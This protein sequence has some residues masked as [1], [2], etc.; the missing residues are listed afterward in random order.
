MTS[1]LAEARFE[2]GLRKLQPPWS[3][4]RNVQ[5]RSLRE[6]DFILAHPDHGLF[7]VE[8]KG[9]TDYEVDGDRLY[10]HY[11]GRRK[12]VFAQV[13]DQQR[14]LIGLCRNYHLGCSVGWAVALP[15]ANPRGAFPHA[16]K[17][18][19]AA[20]L[21][22]LGGRLERLAESWNEEL[23]RSRGLGLVGVGDRE[24]TRLRLAFEHDKTPRL[25]DIR[26]DLTG[27]ARLTAEQLAAARKVAGMQ[28]PT[29]TF[30]GGAGSGKTVLALKL[31]EEAACAG[32]RVLYLCYNRA[33]KEWLWRKRDTV[34]DVEGL[35]EHLELAHFHRLAH[36]LARRAGLGEEWD[37]AFEADAPSGRQNFWQRTSAELLERAL[38]E[39]ET[40]YDLVIV[41]EAQ[42]FRAPWWPAVEAL[43]KPDGR[44]IIFTDEQQDVFGA[45]GVPEQLNRT[46]F[47]LEQNVRNTR[48][49]CRFI[50]E[51][52]AAE[53]LKIE[54]RHCADA[55]PG[56]EPERLTADE[57]E[58]TVAELLDGG[59]S[60]RQLALLGPFNLEK[61][62][63]VG[64][65]LA[66]RSVVELRR[67]PPGDDEL[68]YSTIHS[69]KGL[70]ADAVFVLDETR[71]GRGLTPELRYV[72]YSRARTRLFV[73]EEPR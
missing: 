6:Y 1:N 35:Y 54:L 31:A 45:A 12:D 2:D 20:E 38:D 60:P 49:I 52:L 34:W 71:H 41:D 37:A 13:W 18:I 4:W 11:D 44:L 57:L 7:V 56:V 67:R 51:Q 14:E 53:G 39:L 19:R 25:L 70:E 32:R 29:L 66:G 65:E 5:P 43:R 27:I 73:V 10:V 16:D 21:A 26:D 17:L 48:S 9:A 3:Y 69:F 8:V 30:S 58:R 64:D 15:H 62:A 47:P 50:N 24:L 59:F 68:L 72:G 36:D 22:D 46:A 33:L 63:L 23:K 55:A 42:D 28:I 61:S 40:R